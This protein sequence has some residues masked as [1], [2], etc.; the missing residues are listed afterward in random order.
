MNSLAKA[1]AKDTRTYRVDVPWNS[2]SLIEPL[3]GGLCVVL[4]QPGMGK[5]ALSLN[6]AL[7]IASPSLLVSLDTD[8]TTQAIRAASIVS[9]RP[10]EEVKNNPQAW[11]NYVHQATERVRAYDLQVDAREV[12]S[13]VRA[14]TEFWGV[15]PALTVLD[16]I[17]N[18]VREGDYQEYRKLFVDL[19]RVA[20][21]GDTF[22]MALHHVNRGPSPGQPLKLTDGQFSGE[23]EAEMVLGLWT[24]DT[25]YLNVSVLKNRSG[26]ADPSGR[27]YVTLRFDKQTMQIR[28]LTQAEEA[29]AVLKGAS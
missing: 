16:N 27:L 17:S 28:D 5:S 6:W 22:V 23:Q 24:K 18:L 20:R 12:L 10:M 1:L 13:I 15:P 25:D 14:E 11:A 7:G 4:A 21:A 2:L 3:R 26:Q 9:G 29:L 8:L 19:H